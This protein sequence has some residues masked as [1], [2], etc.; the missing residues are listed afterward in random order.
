LRRARMIGRDIL[1]DVF[2]VEVKL[3]SHIGGRGEFCQV[4]L[5]D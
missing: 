1:L 3:I 2:E 4:E 5:L